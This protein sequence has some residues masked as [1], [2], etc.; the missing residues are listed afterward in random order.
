MTAQYDFFADFELNA[1]CFQVRRSSVL[2]HE[3]G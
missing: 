3:F 1:T 2:P